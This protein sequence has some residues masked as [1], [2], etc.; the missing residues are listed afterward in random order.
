MQIILQ[1]KGRALDAT[2][3]AAAAIR[4]RASPDDQKL[5]DQF[6]QARSQLAKST[7][8][9]PCREGI[10]KHRANLKVLE[11]QAEKL[12]NELS[13]RSL[14]FRAQFQ[15][16]TKPVTIADVQRVIPQ[17]AALVEFA[18][19]RPYNAKEPNKKKPGAAFHASLKK[20]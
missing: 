12:E 18:A 2:I 14:D 9:G 7:L 4:R 15:V 5:I 6:L 17:N 16:Q 13:L 11:E 1:R 19:F 20:C 8:K 10:E 3:D